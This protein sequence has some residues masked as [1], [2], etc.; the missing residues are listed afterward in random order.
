MC[1]ISESSDRV[2]SSRLNILWMKVK[3]FIPVEHHQQVLSFLYVSLDRRCYPLINKEKL[4]RPSVVSALQPLTV[5][6][7]NLVLVSR[8]APLEPS[9]WMTRLGCSAA[10]LAALIESVDE[11]SFVSCLT[12]YESVT[13]RALRDRRCHDLREDVALLR[14]MVWQVFRESFIRS[15]LAVT[16]GTLGSE[17][18]VLLKQSFDSFFKIIL[19]YLTGAMVDER[20]SVRQLGSLIRCYEHCFILGHQSGDPSTWIVLVD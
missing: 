18:R 1:P 3:E 11:T 15:P 14:D 9:P 10:A 8:H 16:E 2:Y 4:Y 20:K 13:E 6:E 5:P 7:T 19:Y 17:W 12:V